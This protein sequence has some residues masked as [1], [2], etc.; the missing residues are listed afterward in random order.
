MTECV[1]C[2]QYIIGITYQQTN[3]DGEQTIFCSVSC[4]QES[5]SNP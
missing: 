1:Y 3:E 2:G 5:V 4:I